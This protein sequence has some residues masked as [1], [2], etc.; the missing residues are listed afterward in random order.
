MGMRK[1]SLD[2]LGT[3]TGTGMW[4]KG[5]RGAALVA[6]SALA[7]AGCVSAQGRGGTQMRTV[8]DPAWGM[9]AATVT[10]PAGWKFDGFAVHGDTCIS[11]TP[12]VR[13][14]AGTADG[15]VDLQAYP[16]ITYFYNS[17]GQLNQQQQ[18]KGCLVTQSFEPADFLRNVV[19]RALRPGATP[20]VQVSSNLPQNFRQHVQEMSMYDQ[21]Y[22]Q[23]GARQHTEGLAGTVEMDFQRGNVMMAEV[24]K[25][26]FTCVTQQPPMGGTSVSCTIGNAFTVT[27]PKAQ[28]AYLLAN[29]VF[30]AQASPA[31]K[32]QSVAY[33]QQRGQ[34]QLAQNGQVIAQNQQQLIAHN[35]QLIADQQKRFESGQ[36]Q[37]KATNDALHQTMQNAINATGDNQVMQDPATGNTVRVS[38]QYSHTY[39]DSTGRTVLQTNSAFAPGPATMWQEL[40]PR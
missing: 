6:V 7:L 39:L 1:K 5:L 35:N 8:Q 3:G 18:G 14:A 9:T 21:K 29:P 23:M 19:A 25:G 22:A 2:A 34:R 4:G 10:M 28:I 36:A 37:N 11:A 17:N 40:Q 20:Q 31:W 32:Q 12:G 16:E 38:N 30:F 27:A 26:N 15:S 33:Q 13:M 24:F